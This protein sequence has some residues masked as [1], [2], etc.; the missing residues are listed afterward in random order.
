[1][2]GWK[3][4]YFVLR[5]GK[6]VYYSGED[7]KTK[8]GAVE[9]GETTS[10]TLLRRGQEVVLHVKTPGR[11]LEVKHAD[12]E[13]TKAWYEACREHITRQAALARAKTSSRAGTDGLPEGAVLC[14]TMGKSKVMGRESLGEGWAS[15][16]S[17][18]TTFTSR[19]FVLCAEDGVEGEDDTPG[20]PGTSFA[21]NYYT[22]ESCKTQRGRLS[23]GK[24]VGCQF[25]TTRVPWGK[26]AAE[27]LKFESPIFLVLSCQ[28]WLVVLCPRTDEEGV[29]WRAALDTVNALRDGEGEERKTLGSANGAREGG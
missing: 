13:G 1:V 4:R 7:A 17:R 15:N 5:H 28:D 29:Q 16:T 3:D 25:H 21:L 18:W 8:R 6:L 10:L 23:L 19:Y 24:G 9:L 12:E 2:R 14:G 20:E 11:V 22:D 26:H 27:D